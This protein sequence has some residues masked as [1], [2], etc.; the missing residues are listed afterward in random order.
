[1][2]SANHIMASRF[3]LDT[4]IWFSIFH[5]NRTELFIDAIEQLEI[6]IISSDEQC[7]EILDVAT[8]PELKIINRKPEEYILFI[9]SIAEIYESQK[10]FTL[11]IDYKDNYLVDL[12]W[13]SKSILISDDRHFAPLRKMKSPKIELQSKNDFYKILNWK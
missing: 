3:V 8:R 1:M 11:L 9:N 12:A 5:T 2:L 6:S 13:Q 4:H 10:R 7:K